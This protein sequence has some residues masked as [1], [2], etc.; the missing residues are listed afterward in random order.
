MYPEKWDAVNECPT[1]THP[2]FRTIVKKI[3]EMVGEIEFEIKSMQRSGVDFIS[4]R[5]LRNRI[6]QVGKRAKPMKILEYFDL[7]AEEL[8]E[9]G[10]IGYS[11][12]F[13]S[14]K[15]PLKKYLITDK[16]FINFTKKDFEEYEKYLRISGISES[17][18][19]VYVRTFNR[20]WNM[21]ITKGYCPKEHHP[22][23]YFTFKAYRRFKTKKR[24][25]SAEV[26][27]SITALDFDKSSR[28]YRSQ[29]IFLFSYYGRGINFNDLAKLKYESNL[30]GDEITYVRSKNKR[31]YNYQLHTKA[32][33][34][35]E[36]FRTCEIQSDAGYV[37]PILMV[38]HDTP[39][40]I[41][42][43]IDSALKDLNE[44][45]KSI[46]KK[47]GLKKELTSYV[48]R[49]SFATNLRQKNVDLNIIQ[50]AM[51]H[52]TQ[53]QTMTYLEEIDDSVIAKQIEEAL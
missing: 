6:R 17:T 9:Q 30:K 8:K 25:V 1:S 44:D 43:R 42:A 47:I 41:D 35:I 14:A 45:L 23:K 39:Q 38:R 18:I 32:L 26:I 20:L 37:F 22:S 34:I 4:L 36:W 5:E 12:V 46:A 24:A 21:A 49:H 11:A 52:E 13:T 53:L 40:K 16:L 15:S 51:G 19:S 3:N 7:V 48:A 2:K 31:R 28:I 33:S 27:A 10:R 29:Q 50:E